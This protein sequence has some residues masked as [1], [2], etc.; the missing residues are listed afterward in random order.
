MRVW[1]NQHTYSI[2]QEEVKEGQSNYT[3]FYIQHIINNLFCVSSI[4]FMLQKN[5]CQY[6][7]CQRNAA[8]EEMISKG[9]VEMLKALHF[10]DDFL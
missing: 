7:L 2:R 4:Q 10:Y 9:D 8:L 5:C 6:Y 3:Y 1:F